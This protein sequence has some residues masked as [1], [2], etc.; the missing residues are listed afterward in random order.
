MFWNSNTETDDIGEEMEMI[1]KPMN[2][3]IKAS[4]FVCLDHTVAASAVI[5]IGGIAVIGGLGA[6]F[7]RKRGTREEYEALVTQV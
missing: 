7:Y 3:K 1:G 5:M 6:Y 4:V 2:R